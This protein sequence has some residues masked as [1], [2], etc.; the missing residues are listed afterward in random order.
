MDLKLIRGDTHE[1]TFKLISEDGG[2]C[3]LQ[4]SDKVYFTV[5]RNFHGKNCVLQ[6]TLGKGINYRPSTNEYVVRLDQNCSCYLECGQYVYDIKVVI[7]SVN[8]VLV[9]TLIKGHLTFDA[10][11]THKENER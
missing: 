9:K 1:I 7:N 11:A 3:I 5:K 8:P 10:N 2:N 6:K 4:D